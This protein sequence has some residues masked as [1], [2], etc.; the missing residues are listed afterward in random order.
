MFS[1]AL[2]SG[3][4]DIVDVIVEDGLIETIFLFA[5]HDFQDI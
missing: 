1:N 3:H 5:R 2:P 4:F